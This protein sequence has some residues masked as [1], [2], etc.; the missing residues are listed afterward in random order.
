M[1]INTIRLAALGAA[2]LAV[3][4]GAGAAYA[5][6]QTAP[7]ATANDVLITASGSQSLSLTGGVRTTVLTATLP[8]GKWVVSGSGDLV[9]FGPSDYTRCSL[10]VGSTQI[11]GVST[12]VG[13]PDSA[14]S[15]G[16]SAFLSTFTATGGVSLGSSAT[17]TLGCWHDNNVSSAGY[18]D[19]G[20]V[21]H[22]HKS[23]SLQLVSQAADAR[24]SA[25]PPFKPTCYPRP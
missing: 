14:G 22:I 12:I 23:A 10:N 24:G 1:H 20:A 5:G 19:G 16:P 25:C 7:L 18:V 4:A 21:V 15:Q 2:A 11:A 3:F 17:L 8:A 9:D 13:N 6:S